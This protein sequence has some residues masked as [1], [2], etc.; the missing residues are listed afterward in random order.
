MGSRKKK[1][2][3][4]AVDL[5]KDCPPPVWSGMNWE[6]RNHPEPILIS[7]TRDPAPSLAAALGAGSAPIPDVNVDL[8]KQVADLQQRVK[9]LEAAAAADSTAAE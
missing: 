3:K 2:A 5:H 8:R 1:A 7:K 6:C 9:V 4:A